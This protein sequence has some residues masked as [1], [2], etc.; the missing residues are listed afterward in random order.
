MIRIILSFEN[1]WRLLVTISSRICCKLITELTDSL[2]VVQRVL[3]YDFNPPPTTPFSLINW[4][5]F[6]FAWCEFLKKVVTIL[7]RRNRRSPKLSLTMSHAIKLMQCAIHQ[8]FS[9]FGNLFW[10]ISR[11]F[12]YLKRCQKLRPIFDWPQYL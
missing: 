4:D 5:N 1:K 11:A 12:W 6:A 9:I 8:T 7:I 3:Q 10:I 2:A